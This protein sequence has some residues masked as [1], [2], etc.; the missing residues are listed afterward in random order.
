MHRDNPST[1][2]GS[3]ILLPHALYRGLYVR[4]ANRLGVDPS[5]VSRVARGERNSTQVENAL[6]QDIQEIS[7][8]LGRR[9]ASSEV[10]RVQSADTSKRLKSFVKR[11]RSWIRREWLRHN[12]SDPN[13]RK[14]RLSPR[15]RVSPVM[16][17]VDEA[18]QIMKFS[19]RQIPTV[20]VGN[21]HQGL[22]LAHDLI[23]KPVPTFPD[24]A[25]TYPQ[26]L[27]LAM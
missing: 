4:V 16:P 5:Y 1:N 20:D 3:E 27:E 22:F 24:H 8:K 17:V 7:R 2:P 19:V 9:T 13:S 10:A 11:N 25:L 15:K 18:V 21:T 23:R 6:R 14:I 26:R 12:Q